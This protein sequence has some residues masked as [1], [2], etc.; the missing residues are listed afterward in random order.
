M[1]TL[2]KIFLL[3]LLIMATSCKENNNEPAETPDPGVV[4]V[5]RLEK[6][7]NE[8]LVEDD[9]D[10]E[11]QSMRESADDILKYRIREFPKIWAA[12]ESQPW[13]LEFVATGSNVERIEDVWFD[14]HDDYTFEYGSSVGVIGTGKYHYN[15]DTRIIIMQDDRKDVKPKEF[16]VTLSGDAMVWVGSKVYKDNHIQMKLGR[17]DVRSDK[18]QAAQ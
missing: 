17:L 3:G 7:I 2:S 10:A 9:P 8:L 6:E 5:E 1:N 14:F 15:N 11:V 18:L 4:D 12:I 16:G 13:R